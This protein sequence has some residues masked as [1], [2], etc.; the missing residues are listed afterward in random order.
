[1]TRALHLTSEDAAAAGPTCG[2]TGKIGAVVDRLRRALRPRGR[3]AVVVVL[4][5]AAAGGPVASSPAATGTRVGSGVHWAGVMIAR[6]SS[7][8]GAITGCTVTVVSQYVAITAAHCGTY[9]AHLKVNTARQDASHGDVVTIAQ[10]VRH[11][12]LDV[13][14]LLFSRA[15]GLPVIERS[16]AMHS[17]SFSVWGYGYNAQNVLNPELTRADFPEMS[18]CGQTPPVQMGDLCWRMSDPATNGACGGDSGAPVTQDGRLIAMM[19]GGAGPKL[20]DGRSD[21]S[22]PGVVRA[23]SILSIQSWLDEMLLL[24]DPLP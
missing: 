11:P 17:G 24:G 12:T 15:T 7:N 10:I 19:T 13:Q 14:A 6:S 16:T 1:M 20:P 8:P 9:K 5:I 23:V 22:K 21:C 18:L 3:T 4:A 2:R